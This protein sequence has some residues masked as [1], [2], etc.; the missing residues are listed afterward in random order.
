M[1]TCK[2]VKLHL[3]RALETRRGQDARSDMRGD[4]NIKDSDMEWDF[5]SYYLFCDVT[6]NNYAESCES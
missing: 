5:W 4:I 1:F 3:F 2:F 6:L